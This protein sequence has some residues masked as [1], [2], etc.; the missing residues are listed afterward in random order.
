MGKVIGFTGHVGVAMLRLESLRLNTEG[1][2]TVP[3]RV[4][5]ARLLTN[6]PSHLKQI[7]LPTSE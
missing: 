2:A 3:L 5:D 4:G 7:T 1:V 6:V